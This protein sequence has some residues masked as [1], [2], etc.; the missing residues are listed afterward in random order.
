MLASTSA[1]RP[2]AIASGN[3]TSRGTRASST[4]RTAPGMR[5]ARLRANAPNDA[6]RTWAS[7]TTMRNGASTCVSSSANA[8]PSR[9]GSAR[10][11]ASASVRRPTSGR[12]M[13]TRASSAAANASASHGCAS[14]HATS[15]APSSAACTLVVLP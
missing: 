6:P 7:S 8:A 10:C 5:R 3:P 12:T 11:S 9:S 4:S 15:G 2:A 1:P 14:Y 13:R